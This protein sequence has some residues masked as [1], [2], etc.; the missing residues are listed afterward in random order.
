MGTKIQDSLMPMPIKEKKSNVTESI[1][2]MNGNKW[3]T[4]ETVG[5]VEV[6]LVKDGLPTLYHMT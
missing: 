6:H 2:D 5:R 3:D 1:V 4:Q